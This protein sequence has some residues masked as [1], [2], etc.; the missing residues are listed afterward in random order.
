MGLLSFFDIEANIKHYSLKVFCESGTGEGVSLSHALNF[1]FEEFYSVEICPDLFKLVCNKFWNKENVHIYTGNSFDF[2]S[3]FCPKVHVP[4]M[5][6]LDAHLPGV[7]YGYS[8]QKHTPDVVMPLEKELEAIAKFRPEGKDVILIDDLRFYST[9]NFESGILS[10]EWRL[11]NYDFVYD[12]FDNTHN[13]KKY[14]NNEGYL[15]LTP[16]EKYN[17]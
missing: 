14:L 9:E 7:D 13:I 12:Y 2:L 3:S 8:L 1:P 16:K 5:F 4:I 6:W 11:P 17:G 10:E 15:K